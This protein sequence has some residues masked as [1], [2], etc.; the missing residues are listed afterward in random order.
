MDRLYDQNYYK[1]SLRPQT[2]YYAI[3]ELFKVRRLK[4]W[5]RLA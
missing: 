1:A 3:L 2:S 5:T 4:H